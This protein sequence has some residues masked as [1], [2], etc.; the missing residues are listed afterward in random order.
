MVNEV[1]FSK[2]I[3]MTFPKFGELSISPI[4][5]IARY[6]D[7]SHSPEPLLFYQES[8]SADFAIT[9]HQSINMFRARVLCSKFSNSG[10]GFIGNMRNESF[11]L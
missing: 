6:E 7:L 3:I 4:L 11:S 5:R 9:F 8:G 1:S 2:G 10:A